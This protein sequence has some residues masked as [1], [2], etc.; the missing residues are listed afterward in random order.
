MATDL[1]QEQI[2]EVRRS[3]KRCR[4]DTIEAIINL[5][6]TGDSSLIPVIMRGIVWRYVRPELRAQV[7]HATPDTP[8]SSLGMD[9]LMMLEV[10][11]DLQDALDVV[12]EDAEL[13][14]VQTIGDVADLLT[15]RFAEKQK[16]A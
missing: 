3:F 7:E 15:Q 10:V 12:I 16:T 11:L 9:S 4:E 1:T 8:L 13:R 5:R 6:R 14:R 2:D